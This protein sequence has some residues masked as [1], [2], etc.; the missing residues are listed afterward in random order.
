VI[1]IRTSLA[2]PRLT[3]T[4]VKDRPE[5]K[6]TIVGGDLPFCGTGRVPDR[7]IGRYQRLGA[8]KDVVDDILLGNV[9]W[10]DIG[11]GLQ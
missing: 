10:A 6:T 4:R 11:C 3:P 8:V 7:A 1:H 2:R 9:R 5:S